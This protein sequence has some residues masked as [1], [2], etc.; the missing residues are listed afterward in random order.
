MNLVHICNLP[1]SPDHPDHGRIPTHPGR[2][3]LNLAL[4]QARH[5]NLRPEL[6]VQVPGTTCDHHTCVEGIP[7]HYLAAPTRLR[8]ATFFWFDAR[9][10]ARAVRALKPDFVHAHGTE[11]AYGLAAQ[12]SGLPYVL[13][14]QGLHFLINSIL[15]PRPISRAR[16]IQFT[17]WACL[18]R[19]H[20]VI[21]KSEYVRTPLAARFPHLATHLVPNTFD[22]A[23]E[24]LR[25]EKEPGTVVFVAVID[26][27]K[28]LHDLREATRQ[29]KNRLPSLKLWIVGNRTPPRSEYE[30]AET[31]A[32]QEI[33]GDRVRFWGT[34]P[35]METASIVARAS[36]LAAPSREEMFGNQVIEALLVGTPVIV[37]EGTAMAENVRRFGNGQI[38]PR[39][40]PA[41]LASAIESALRTPPSP[42]VVAQA[43][44][45]IHAWMAPERVARLHREVYE[46]VM[47]E[48]VRS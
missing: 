48:S 26:P 6:V 1:L 22:P 4:A 32:L 12:R 13:T 44:Q 43:R 20:H 21:A 19:A 36:L 17:E 25:A 2:W 23:L 11:D 34:L 33:M 7:V 5:T 16:M 39:A 15:P 27:R 9:R 45:A 35:A 29:L 3:V 30:A 31:R 28:G 41:A 18:R 46:K 40:D 38:V 24:T 42:E 37:T 10:I 47:K 14:A 8:S